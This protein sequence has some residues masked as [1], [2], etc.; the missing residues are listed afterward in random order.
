[1][2]EGAAGRFVRATGLALVAMAVGVGSVGLW[3]WIE[4]TSTPPAV[5]D[6]Y[7]SERDL[8]VA[9]TQEEEVSESAH[10][11]HMAELRAASEALAA[12][13]LDSASWWSQPWADR[14]RQ[15]IARWSVAGALVAVFTSAF[16]AAW[17]A[18]GPRPKVAP[19]SEQAAT[20]NSSPGP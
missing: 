20:D 9:A 17:Y 10:E 19:E 11:R 16:A 7:P 1:M 3:A 2:T 4:V 18:G 6:E 13:R 5:V 14:S 15:Y 12:A 8:R